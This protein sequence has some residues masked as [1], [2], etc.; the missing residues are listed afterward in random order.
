MDN[1]L[2]DHHDELDR[3]RRESDRGIAV[4]RPVGELDAHS[5]GAF[6]D[7]LEE[8]AEARRLLIDLTEVPFLDSAGLNAL[9]GAV[10]RT[11]DRGGEIAIACGRPS[12]ER[13]LRTTGFD[14]I[15]TV[16]STFDAACADLD[17]P[18]ID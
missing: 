6:R 12:T 16:R 18:P 10:R 14:R 11:R 9:I 7:E 3:S 17:E 8:L 5:V 15:V 4:C 2:L 1:S 13:L